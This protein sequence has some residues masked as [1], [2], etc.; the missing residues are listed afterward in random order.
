MFEAAT[1]REEYYKLLASKIFYI[2]KELE[3]RKN[4]KKSGA[5]KGMNN[6]CYAL[7]LYYKP[8]PLFIKIM[9]ILS[10]R[11]LLY[12]LCE[13]VEC[14]ACSYASST[15]VLINP[16]RMR[17]GYGSRFVCVCCYCASCYIPHL[18]VQSEAS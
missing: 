14:C 4:Q 10:V 3:D 18:Y 9:P 7:Y 6:R 1:D 13:S 5:N 11:K 12:L 16:W 8:C 2:R 17:E 15:A